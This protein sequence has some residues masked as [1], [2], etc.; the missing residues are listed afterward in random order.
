MW[1]TEY[2][3]DNNTTDLFPGI[4]SDGRLFTSYTPDAMQNDNIKRANS[5][6]TNSQY[7]EY[8]T[9]NAISIMQ[10]NF[11]S[12]TLENVSPEFDNTIQYGTPVL[13]KGVHDES[14]P[15]GYECTFPKNI[16]LS[17]ERLDDQKRR[18]MR[19]NYDMN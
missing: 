16:Y 3:T 12:M 19:P 8:L 15:Y 4:L 5:I 10:T 17:R 9:K 1:A 14:T 13:F 7:R 11:K 6:K 18:P 2:K